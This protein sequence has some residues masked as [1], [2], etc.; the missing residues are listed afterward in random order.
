MT[1]TDDP[2]LTLHEFDIDS[3][4]YRGRYRIVLALS[5][6]GTIMEPWERE[7]RWRIDAEDWALPKNQHA[8]ANLTDVTHMPK[9][10]KRDSD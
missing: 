4:I 2:T 1:Y 3:N 10:A 6:A 5:V 8:Y 9:D 7:M